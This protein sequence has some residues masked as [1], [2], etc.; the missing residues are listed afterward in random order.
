MIKRLKICDFKSIRELDLALDP[1]TVLVGRSGTGKSNTVQ[2]LRFLRNF[3]L[4]GMENAA[5]YEWG[6]ER[7]VPVGEK[8]PKPSIEVTFSLPGEDKD[9]TYAVSFGCPGQQKFPGQILLRAERLALG[10]SVVFSRLRRDTN[11]WEWEKSPEVAALPHQADGPMLGSFPSLQK[12]VFAYAGLSSSI[13]YYHFPASTLGENIGAEQRAQY[14][15][16]IPGLSDNA[17]NYREIIRGITQ[18]FHRPNV[19]KSLLASLQAINPN[20]ASIELDSLNNPQRAVVGHTA[21]GRIFEL[22]LQ[23]ES[24]GFRRFYA[25][26][27]ALYQSPPKLTLIFEEPENAIYPGA[28]SLLADEFKAAPNENRGQVIITTHNP[29]LLDSFDVDNVRVVEMRDGKTLVGPVSKEQT[30][31]VKDH[32]LT[33]GELL[34]ID[35]P[36]IDE[37]QLA[38]QPA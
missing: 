37:S 36:R 11:Q 1:V 28:L 2:A 4:G 6:W 10:T 14:L 21:A 7:I 5:N 22:S 31:A 12:V 16:H 34:K 19:R 35:Q 23:Q 15:Q 25:H 27:L 18:D 26:L 24:D 17:H 29:T 30:A 38:A 32:L 20:I 9:Y 3:L 13:G 8:V 33:T